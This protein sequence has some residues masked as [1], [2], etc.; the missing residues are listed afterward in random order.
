MARGIEQGDDG[1]PLFGRVGED[2][3]HLALGQLAGR[4]GGI[5]SIARLHRRSYG[6]AFIRSSVD[7]DGH[8]VEQEAQALVAERQLDVG[9]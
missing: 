7:R 4:V 9:V 1:N 5:A 2:C 8:I 6:V 3:V